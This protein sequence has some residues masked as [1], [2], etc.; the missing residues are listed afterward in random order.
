MKLKTNSLL[1]LVFSTGMMA[2]DLPKAPLAARKPHVHREHGVERHE[3]VTHQPV[4]EGVPI[5][6]C[7]FSVV[8]ANAIKIVRYEPLSFF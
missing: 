6:V 8:L 1:L 3:T 4:P 7:F 5:L 2:A